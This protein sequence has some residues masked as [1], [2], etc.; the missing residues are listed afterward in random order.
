MDRDLQQL[1]EVN[2][3]GRVFVTCSSRG[4][5]DLSVIQYYGDVIRQAIEAGVSGDASPLA[6]NRLLDEQI[7]WLEA[8]LD[9]ERDAREEQANHV[10]VDVESPQKREK[11]ESG[12]VPEAK[13]M[14][15]KLADRRAGMDSLL[16]NECVSLKLITPGQA[17]K[18]TR[19][20]LG[21]DPKVAEEEVVVELRN[22]LYSQI[23]QFIRSHKGGPWSSHNAQSDLRMDIASTK[24]VSA[25][26]TLTQH[27][28]NERDEWLQDN[29]GGLTGRF[30]GG[31]F[32]T[33]R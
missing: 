8:E 31:R 29:K 33:K 1:I 24:S 6:F 18:M 28:F 21:K 27:I 14:P 20:F 5:T 17:K 25:V 12:Y 10:K 7:A 19:R 11:K 30:F 22:T 13:S 4:I 9:R 23:R 16:K 3:K 26:V 32:W 15:E 2:A